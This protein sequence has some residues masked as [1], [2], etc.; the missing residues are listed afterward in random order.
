M[1]IL[2]VFRTVVLLCGKEAIREALV[3]K[4]VDFAD[5]PEVF[6]QLPKGSMPRFTLTVMLWICLDC[7]TAT[8]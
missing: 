3:T 5:R 7:S 6:T 1:N 8:C 4:S 2:I